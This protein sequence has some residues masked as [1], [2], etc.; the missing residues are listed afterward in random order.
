MIIANQSSYK[1]NISKFKDGNTDVMIEGMK[2]R[3]RSLDGDIVY[4]QLLPEE[5]WKVK[6]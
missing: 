2:K 6:I 5:Q 1:K 4:V 3:N